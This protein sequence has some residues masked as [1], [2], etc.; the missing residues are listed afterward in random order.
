MLSLCIVTIDLA[1]MRRFFAHYAVAAQDA[2]TEW[3]IFCNEADRDTIEREAPFAG[4]RILAD[5]SIGGVN[6]KR[7]YLLSEASGESVMFVDDDGFIEDVP[8]SLKSIREN[9]AEHPWLLLQMRWRSGETDSVVS[10][11]A[12]Q[13]GNVGSGNETNQVYRTAMLRAAGGWNNAFGPGKRWPSGEA[14]VLMFALYKRGLRQTVFDKVTVAHAA[15]KVQRDLSDL[16]KYRRYRA[17]LG[18]VLL[19]LRNKMPL[20]EFVLWLIRFSAVPFLGSLFA[21]GRGDFPL[22]LL[23]FFAPLDLFRGMITFF[24]HKPQLTHNLARIS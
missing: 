16:A 9:A 5:D 13:I 7:N 6:E 21:L 24:R 22:A 12:F 23:R 17:A 11:C 19:Y 4:S 20:S 18:T 3:L 8:N 2:E 15:Q 14:F 10:P 1:R